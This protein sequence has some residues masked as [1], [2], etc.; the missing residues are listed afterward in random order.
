[1]FT[2]KIDEARE[3]F[4]KAVEYNPDFGVAFVQKC[5]ADYRYGILKQRED[6]ITEAMRGFEEAF[7]KFP[8]CPEC[9]TLYAQVSLFDLFE[10]D[11]KLYIMYI[12]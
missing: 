9:Y 4:R 3:D 8:D 6:V 2:E 7:E 5:Y 1:M 10:M 12:Y 11:I